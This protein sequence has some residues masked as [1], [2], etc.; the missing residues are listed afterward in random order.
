MEQNQAGHPRERRGRLADVVAEKLKE[1]II[2]GSFSVG[3]KLPSENALAQ[4]FDV[5]RSSM[6]EAVRTLQA[7]GYLES[8]QGSGVFVRTDKPSV[9]G[10][11][12][13][14]LVG[15]YTMSDLF[16]ARVAIE[17]QAATLAAVR[18]TE[19]HRQVLQSI[20][21][22]A[23]EPGV[24]Q[25]DFVALDRRFHRQIADASGN[26][27]LLYVWDL[28]SDSFVEYSTK[29]IGL[30]GRLERAHEDHRAIADA[31]FAGDV[32]TAHARTADHVLVVQQE[33]ER[34][35][36]FVGRALINPEHSSGRDRA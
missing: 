24:S 15:G 4:R 28:I 35:S 13:M 33:L 32:E 21:N 11:V 6:R 9:I 22:S 1:E 8:A 36:R 27:L 31:L 25:A 18:L 3:S 34:A 20:L 7:S 26:P 2:S 17:C 16:E 12:D 10:P 5:G 14:S 19:H 30:P 23:S 29:V